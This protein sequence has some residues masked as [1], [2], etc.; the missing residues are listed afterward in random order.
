MIQRKIHDSE[1]LAHGQQVI[2]ACA[3]IYHDFDG[4]TKVFLPKRAATKKFLPSVYELP[5]GI[6]T[7]GKIL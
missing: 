5:G 6:L 1:T 3:F 4:V 2:T 7:M